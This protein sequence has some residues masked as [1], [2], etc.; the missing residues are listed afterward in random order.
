M[1]ANDIKELYDRRASAMTRRPAFG[2]GSGQARV[3]MG[4]GFACEVEHADGTFRV[5]QPASEGGEGGGP[6]P[7]QLMSASLG[8]CLAMGYRIWGA[9]LG[10]PIDGVE[11]EVVCC[12][13][14]RGQLG[15]ADDVAIG[16]EE[17]RFDV[18]V[19]SAAPEEAVR[20][21][22]ETSDRRNPMLANLAS[23]VRRV[24]RLTIVR[25]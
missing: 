10:V 12:Y 11:V 16:W 6:H 21:V 17:I 7:G 3:R 23:T 14:V 15:V 19:T 8:A 1:N 20:R 2:R 18:R 24:H 25:P 9:R 5:D 22:V 13:D 4:R